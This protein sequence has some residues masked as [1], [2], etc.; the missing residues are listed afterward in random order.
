MKLN[1]QTADVNK[2][3]LLL[4]IILNSNS[5]VG[6]YLV[7]LHAPWS[8]KLGFERDLYKQEH[9]WFTIE[10]KYISINYKLILINAG[11]FDYKHVYDKPNL[12]PY[13]LWLTSTYLSLLGLGYRLGYRLNIHVIGS[14][15]DETHDINLSGIC[16]LNWSV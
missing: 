14:W 13:I 9:V 16:D 15:I 7:N 5:S 11:H 4:F 12:Y 6:P 10:L 2:S 8:S 1:F 3:I